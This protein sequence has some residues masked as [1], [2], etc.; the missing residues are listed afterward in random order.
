M[1]QQSPR[2]SID[3]VLRELAADDDTQHGAS[4]EVRAGLLDEVRAIGALRRRRRFA[5]GS[6]TAIAASVVVALVV[7]Q[8]PGSRLPSLVDPPA[9]QVREVATAFLPLP[10][11]AAPAAHAY[12]VR[13]D[14]PRT[15]LTRLG[16]GH[17]ET[18]DSMASAT[19][20]ADVLVG[21]DG[22]ARAVRFVH[23]E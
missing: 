13:L 11:A 2:Q 4:A 20:L 7:G 16:L 3:S 10:G 19:I 22:V 17:V 8:R 6:L 23:Q 21:E 1:N 5:A 12:L 15:A 18:L 9:P 14:L